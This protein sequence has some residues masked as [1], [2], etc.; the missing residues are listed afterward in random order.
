MYAA[1]R[2][3]NY[4]T[5]ATFQFNLKLNGMSMEAKGL[6][7]SDTSIYLEPVGDA[8]SVKEDYQLFLPS[9][10]LRGLLI[11]TASFELGKD[12]KLT[13]PS[14][15]LEA[16]MTFKKGGIV[17]GE[18]YELDQSASKK[19]SK[20]VLYT[21]EGNFSN[22]VYMTEV[23]TK[24]KTLLIDTLEERE[25]NRYVQPLHKQRENESRR[26]WHPVTLALT[27]GDQE[28]ASQLKHEIEEV[29]RSKAKLAKA[30]GT[31]H[32]PALF[33]PSSEVLDGIVL[34]K[35]I[36]PLGSYTPPEAE[37]IVDELD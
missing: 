3:N 29:Q 16:C 33:V 23:T 24:S 1:N 10:M 28:K 18:L 2:K 9:V 14:T 8:P 26:V 35:Y 20:N 4:E 36:E 19:K 5:Q 22:Q 32:V 27:K 17:K 12:L 21:F 31:K 25:I 15:G 7:R 6:G 30:N 13:C 37:T 34:H 11:G